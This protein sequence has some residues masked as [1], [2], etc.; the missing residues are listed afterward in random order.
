MDLPLWAK[1]AVRGLERADALDPVAGRLAAASRRV[2]RDGPVADL[3]HGTWLGH[4]LHPV[5][6][7]LPIG[8]WTSAFVLDLFGGDE[9]APAARELVGWGVV[10]AVPTALAGLVDWRDIDDPPSRRLGTAH[11][12]CNVVA[13]ACYTA[14]WAVRRR[15]RSTLGI[16]LGFVGAT[17]ASIAGF[18][19][20]ELV[21]G[22]DDDD[23]DDVDVDDW[24]AYQA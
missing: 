4:P 22:S 16:A 13:L 10:S 20:G 6:T 21:F 1:G 24:G 5:L 11:A 14:S 2:V 18:L 7:D 12:A 23:E 17:A 19:G 3:L 9:Q 8:F 15:R